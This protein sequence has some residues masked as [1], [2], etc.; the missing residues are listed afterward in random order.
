RAQRELARADHALWIMDVRDGEAA[1]ACAARAELGADARPTLVLN[2][3]DLAGIPPAAFEHDGLA[4]LRVSVLTGA[5]LDLLTAHLQSLAG[6][7]REATGTF[8]ARRRHLDALER[9]A[10]HVRAARGRL[11]GE[12]ELGAEE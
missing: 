3:I 5:G 12:L 10:A 4:G 2:K 11:A 7:P 9:A 8:S 1:A 6:W